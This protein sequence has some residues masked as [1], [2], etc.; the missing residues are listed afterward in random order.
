MKTYI[1]TIETPGGPETMK[2]AAANIQEAYGQVAE[3]SLSAAGASYHYS[4]KEASPVASPQFFDGFANASF[5]LM[6]CMILF[7]VFD[8]MLR[9]WLRS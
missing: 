3:R 6:A 9:K 5:A 8:H 2:L 4:I 7:I 1:A